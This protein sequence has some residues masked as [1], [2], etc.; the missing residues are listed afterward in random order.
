MYTSVHYKVMILASTMFLC[1]F[2][3]F[4][5]KYADIETHL[6]GG[7]KGSTSCF[8]CQNQKVCSRQ[9]KESNMDGVKDWFVL[10]PPM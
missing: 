3:Y 1:L 9:E 8:P 2:T 6:N 10:P 5:Y 7:C 4:L